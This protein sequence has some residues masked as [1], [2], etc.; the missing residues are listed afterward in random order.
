MKKILCLIL[1]IML[2]TTCFAETAG[3]QLGLNALESLYDGTHNQM[4]SPIS[5]AIALNMAADG[6]NG[7]TR[8]EILN[9]LQANDTDIESNIEAL[10]QSGLKFANAAFSAS[11]LTVKSDYSDLL[12]TRYGAEW[13]EM[14]DD[15]V[16]RINEWANE[17]TDGL[18]EKLLNESPAGQTQLILLNAVAMDAK[19]LSPFEKDGTTIEEF[20]T[21]NG[22]TEVYMMRQSEY[23]DYAETESA[24][25]LRLNYNNSNLTMLLALPKDG[26]DEKDILSELSEQGLSYF[27]NVTEEQYV[28]IRLP[29]VD[30]EVDNNLNEMLKN[31]GIQ[32]AFN[33]NA[34]FGGI[35]DTPLSIGNVRQKAR[36]MIDEDGTKAAAITEVDIVAMAM[37]EEE[38]VEFRADHPF[39][40][41]IA[42]ESTQTICFAAV[43][44]NPVE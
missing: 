24:Q 26:Y 36:M 37:K 30:I 39:I 32:S 15:I 9:A 22:A 12:K 43:I 2:T 25:L 21:P 27:S 4:I 31:A 35:S 17:H 33:E 16:E 41:V 42:D 7:D 20:Q 28:K 8:T 10:T 23:C 14:G 40:A 11:E 18:I 3:N 5:L 29:K 38:G 6:A 13:F 44:A 34:D 19:W 1:M